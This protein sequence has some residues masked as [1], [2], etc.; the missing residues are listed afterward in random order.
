MTFDWREKWKDKEITAQEAI[1]KIIPGN[2][3]FIDSGCS[4]PQLLTSELIKHSEKLIDTEILHFLTIGPEKYFK[5]KE[6]DLF[7]HN[8]FFIGKTLREEINRGQADYTP[9]FTSEIPSLFLTGR[10]HIDVALIQATPPD[11][12][13][14]CSLGINVDIAKPIAQSSYMTI[15]EINPQ[16]PR[17]LG[18]SF[19]H[20]KEIDYF[21]YN[22]TSLLEFIFEKPDE[23]AKR[24]GK[25]LVNLIED[26]STIHVGFGDL[27]NAVLPFLTEK[28]DLGMHSHYITDNIIPLIEEGILTCRKKN[29]HPEKI[30]TSFALGTKKL[31]DFVHNNP[32]IEF[33]PSDYVCN[34]RYI[35]MNKKM[36]SINSAR[37]IDL[38]GQINAATEGYRFYSGLGETIDFMRGAA[39]SKGGK[40]III[41]PST[42]RDGKKSRIVAHL[43]EGA[44]I[45]LSRGDVHY[46]VTEW[47]VAYLHGKSIRERVLELICIAHP[48]FRQSLLDEAKKLNYIYSDQLLACDA[49]GNIC[50]YPT[51]YETIYSISN[52]EKVRIRPVKTTDEPLLRDLYYSLSER[53][54]YLRFFE[55]K[56]E[57]THSKTQF[58]VNIDYNDIFSIGAFIGEIGKEEMIGNATYYL[59]PKINMGEYSFLVRDDYRGKG[60]GGFLYQ[61]IVIIAKERGLK[62]LYGN[63]H[64]Q[65]KSAVR[66]IKTGGY[67]KITPPS[68]LEEKELFYE[69]FFDKEDSME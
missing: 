12:Y 9:I 43:D 25:N 3:V 60:I 41:I 28:K 5:D 51:Q 61:H 30:I 59:N 32:Y 65:N 15:V 40:P 14:F 38:T 26:K 52:K 6:E 16:M 69:V 56:K 58:E 19:I 62:G 35:G 34:P 66:I 10:K 42:S 31:Y 18:N 27:P 45:M 68:S 7:R 67:T 23:I 29:F 47:G 63:I 33:Y 44:G 50:I 1:D 36:V 48:N 53:D 64:I 8:A 39:F 11:P 57:F 55:L 49:K 4:E 21:V 24:I 54:R 46:V 37:Q 20:M 17:T 13:G 22:D 2:R